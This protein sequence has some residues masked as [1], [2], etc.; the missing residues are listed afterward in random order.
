M[1]LSTREDINAPIDT[2]FEAVSR[3]EDY[4]RAAMRRGIEVRR[5]GNSDQKGLGASWNMRLELR[6][7]PRSIDLEVTQFDAPSDLVVSL[8]S[9]NI[10]G[11]MNCD[12]FE[13]SR[14]RTR[15]TIGVEVRPLTLSARLLIQ[16][17]KLTKNR[18]SRKYKDRVAELAAEIESRHRRQI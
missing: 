16:S 9:R 6:G 2:V 7:K 15:L 10:T 12:L 1:K 11:V 8:N 3:F 14:N 5:T 18:M 17:L 13:L 4:E